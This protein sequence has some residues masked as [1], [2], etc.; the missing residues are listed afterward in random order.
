MTE[1]TTV[2]PSSSSRPWWDHLEA[3]AR[4]RIRHWLQALLEEDVTTG[5]G[6]PRFARRAAVDAPAGY[7]KGYGKP[8]QLTVSCGT[9]TVR[10]P[11]VRGLAERVVSRVLPLFQRRTKPVGARLPRLSLHGVALG[12]FELALQGL[13]GEGA[14]LSPASL[15]R[16]KEKWHQEYAA[17]K[18]R[19]LDA[20]EV[21]DVWA[22]GLSVQAGLEA[23]TAALL[24][25]IGAPTD[26]RNVVLAVER[27]RR[28]S[29]ESWG[30]VLR[31]L[32]A[33]GLKP[34]RCTIADGHLGM[35]AA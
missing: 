25:V 4:A 5:L 22:D 29:K 31:A 19:R 23:G 12:D 7:R 18:P 16:L 6:R 10:R 21:G 9:I 28:A 8:R 33:R 17:W 1:P 30:A 13:V 15:Q 20:L 32:R 2:S 34:W 3:C 14:P 27:G 35:G 26:G 11:R 24:V